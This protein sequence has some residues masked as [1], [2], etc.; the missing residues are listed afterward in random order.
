[1]ARQ[2]VATG[3]QTS[4]IPHCGLDAMTK[5]AV[6]SN[7]TRPRKKARRRNRIAQICDT[8]RSLPRMSELILPGSRLRC[9]GMVFL[10]TQHRWVSKIIG[11]SSSTANQQH[12]SQIGLV[13]A[14]V[15]DANL[16][17]TPI[18]S[19][20]PR[21]HPADRTHPSRCEQLTPL[22]GRDPRF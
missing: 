19:L 10:E 22:K 20:G 13:S 5:S 1:M 6:S 18:A 8:A 14:V 16:S 21:R 7:T 17:C 11:A 4:G 12:L 3:L 2:W 15:Q 9:W